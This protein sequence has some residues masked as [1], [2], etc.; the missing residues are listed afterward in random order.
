VVGQARDEPVEPECGE[1]GRG[2]FDRQR[3]PVQL[4]ADL[5]DPVQ[6]LGLQGPAH[7]G[8]PVGKQRDRIRRTDVAAV[9]FE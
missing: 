2:E 4:P 1:A 6:V 8:G 3:H 7:R 9:S 5:G